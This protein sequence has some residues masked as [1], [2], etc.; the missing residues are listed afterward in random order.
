MFASVQFD[1]S[2]ADPPGS[3]VIFAATDWVQGTLLGTLATVIAVIA[4]AA[5]GLLMLSGRVGGRRGVTVLLGCFVLFGAP[6]VALG[7]R[8]TVGGVEVDYADRAVP[9]PEFPLVAP[10][11]LPQQKIDSFDPYAG[12]A[13]PQ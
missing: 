6:V 9:M 13:V 8:G 11:A 10:R 1:T 7:F 5:I 3:S 12:A 2:L 4:V